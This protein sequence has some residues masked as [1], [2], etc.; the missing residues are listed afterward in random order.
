MIRITLNYCLGHGTEPDAWA[1][2]HCVT[3]L[4]TGF[5]HNEDST[6]NL[7]LTDYCFD[8]NDDAV[9]FALRWCK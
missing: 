9:L 3:Y 2:E 8:G 7:T 4:G 1:K 6:Y 5:H